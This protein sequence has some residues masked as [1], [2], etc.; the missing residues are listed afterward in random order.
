MPP[1]G[2]RDGLLANSSVHV[3]GRTSTQGGQ[4]V[5]GQGGSGT[6]IGTGIV[7]GTVTGTGTGTG[8][9]MGTCITGQMSPVSPGGQGYRALL[10]N[11]PFVL[12]LFAYGIVVGVFCAIG[13]LINGIIL[14]RFGDT[15]AVVRDCGWAGAAL[16]LAGLPGGL[17]CGKFLDRTGMFH[18]TTRALFALSSMSMA[19][20]AAAVQ[21]GTM[22][23]VITSATAFGFFIT[24]L[25]A[26][27]FEFAAELTYPITE[28][29][30]AALL[31]AMGQGL[32]VVFIVGL[33]ALIDHTGNGYLVTNWAMTGL[34]V[35]GLG[36]TVCCK[37]Q[38]KRRDLDL[39][40]DL[41]AAGASLD[42]VHANTIAAHAD[43]TSVDIHSNA[44]GVPRSVDT[45]GCVV[46]CGAG[47]GISATYRLH[48]R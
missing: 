25:I 29:K 32:G 15:P 8:T 27:G 1:L 39:G 40:L 43:R 30:T 7:T 19:A 48:H 20:F 28:E 37:G 16:V 22:V 33:Q 35:I 3:H 45:G 2:E 5:Q 31:N 38:L 6:G 26:A 4:R 10:A 36:L 44:I 46:L 13:T 14:P 42:A 9:D 17:L 21:W 18:G 41:A 11:R 24:G 23:H 47:A 34:L 12:L